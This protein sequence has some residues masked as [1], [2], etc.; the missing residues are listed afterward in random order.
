MNN[1]LFFA[2]RICGYKGLNVLSKF[3]FSS[4][5]VLLISFRSSLQ[6]FLSGSFDILFRQRLQF[7]ETVAVPTIF[8]GSIP[9]FLVPNFPCNFQHDAAILLHFSVIDLFH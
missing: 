9:G 4:F 1:L 8:H 3:P 6:K 5:K 2:K 7:G